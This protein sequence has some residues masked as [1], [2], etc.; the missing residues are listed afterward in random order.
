MVHD[1]D[2]TDELPDLS[3]KE[4][5]KILLEE[6][7]CMYKE[8]SAD[9]ANLT[10]RVDGVESRL[11]QVESNLHSLN[12]KVDTNHLTFMRH[13]ESYDKRITALEVSK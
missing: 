12:I 1:D 3:N 4:I 5:L 8:H 7:S 10:N 9:I 11:D 6:M 13:I 2:N